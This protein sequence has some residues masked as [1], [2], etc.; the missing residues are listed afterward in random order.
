MIL[1]LLNYFVI[2]NLIA[3]PRLTGA[4]LSHAVFDAPDGAVKRLE[5]RQP[6]YRKL[7]IMRAGKFSVKWLN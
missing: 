5:E 3:R 1:L 6:F 7:C 4:T 2:K